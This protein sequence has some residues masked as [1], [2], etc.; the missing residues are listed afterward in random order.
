MPLI[1]QIYS[2]KKL[3]K[4]IFLTLSMKENNNLIRKKKSAFS[5]LVA[6]FAVQKVLIFM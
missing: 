1:V 2:I 3:K 5:L 4:H 6:S